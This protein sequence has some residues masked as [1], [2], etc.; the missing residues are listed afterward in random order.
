MNA[1]EIIHEIEQ[2]PQTERQ[3]L[4]EYLDLNQWQIN[5]IKQAVA[6]ADRGEFASEKE[7]EEFLQ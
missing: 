4:Q 6:S 2:L 7:V 5:Q 1:E 3:K